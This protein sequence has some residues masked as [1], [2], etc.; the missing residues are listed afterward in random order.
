MVASV[1]ILGDQLLYKHPALV[2]AE[3]QVSRKQ[4]IVLIIENESR[5]RRL[6]YQRKKLV[7]LFS[8]MRHFADRLR[9]SGYQVDYRV[10]VTTNSAI[11]EHIQTYQP[12]MVYTMA[13][14][15]FRGRSYQQNLPNQFNVPVNILPNTQFL[16]G[17]FNPIP[18]PHPEKRYRQEQFYRKMR[19]HFDLMMEADGNP[20]GGRWNFDKSNRRSLPK[21]AKPPSRN[22][23]EPDQITI[24][25]MDEVDQKYQG[26][27]KTS[28]F[29]LAVTH[30]QANLAAKDFFDNRLP[31]FGA[32]EDAM[33]SVYSTIFHSR[34]SPYLNL[35]LLDPLELA[36]EAQNRFATRHA[37]INS[38]E[39][40]IRQVIGWREY[41]YWQYWRLMPEIYTSNY[42]HADRPL[43]S[44]FWNGDT[45]INCLSHVIKR[46]LDSGYTHHIERLMIES[47]FCLLA[48]IEPIAVNDWFLSAYIDSYEWVM[49]PNVIGMGLY[50]DGG[51]IATKPY[52]AS[53]NYINKMSDY[54]GNCVFDHRLRIGDKACPFNYLYW[55]FILEHE[56]T[57]RSNPR[58]ARNLLGLKHLDNEQRSQVK[59]NAHQFLDNLK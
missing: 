55:N 4:L 14:S 59:E 24:E 29:D 38:V 27:G 13:A 48:G 8:A 44:M 53:A 6:P 31:D 16:T 32:Y 17:R 2:L 52:I 23:F 20:V 35:G 39:G 18:D 26:L 9:S 33:S 21:D 12:E 28:G 42:W 50:A 15:E 46:A 41:M 22:S 56:D 40:F 51:V 49:L 47:N 43:P 30:K 5:A 57:L 1:W 11:N 25:V 45:D 19:K 37:P 7:L 3:E 10:S 58:M 36:K 34:L 54:C